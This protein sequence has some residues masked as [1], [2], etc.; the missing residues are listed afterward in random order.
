MQSES[1]DKVQ[2]R[3]SMMTRLVHADGSALATCMLINL[4]ATGAGLK[5]TNSDALPAHFVLL[6]SHSGQLCRHC[7]VESQQG[8][9]VTV[10]F[11]AKADGHALAGPQPTS[12]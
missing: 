1:S 9:E 10:R 8:P 7:V 5:L 6:L 2:R 3:V 11:V 12:A 4:S